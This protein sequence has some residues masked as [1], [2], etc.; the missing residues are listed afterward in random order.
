VADEDYTQGTLSGVCVAPQNDETLKKEKLC[1]KKEESK[2]RN[3]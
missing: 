1:K 3:M 2:T